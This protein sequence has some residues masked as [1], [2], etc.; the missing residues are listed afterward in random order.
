MESAFGHLQKINVHAAML[1]SFGNRFASRASDF[2]NQ[3]RSLRLLRLV[4]EGTIFSELLITYRYYDFIG[5]FEEN[6]SA[7][8]KQTDRYG[9]LRFVP[10][11]NKFNGQYEPAPF[12]RREVG[13]ILC[14]FDQDPVN[15][16]VVLHEAGHSL[17]PWRLLLIA[18]YVLVCGLNKTLLA[19]G[20][21]SYFNFWL[22]SAVSERLADLH[23]V[24]NCRKEALVA[25]SAHFQKHALQNLFIHFPPDTH[26][27]PANRYF[28]L[29]RRIE[30]LDANQEKFSQPSELPLKLPSF[31]LLHGKIIIKNE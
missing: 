26:P 28:L 22:A 27:S 21:I 16:F 19:S 13:T 23:A 2:F 29:Q 12:W 18:N 30:Q 25:A 20:I 7:Y 8:L 9:M 24:Q 14:N 17:H 10:T 1:S 6:P 15:E 4:G 5:W 3:N 11:K 31:A